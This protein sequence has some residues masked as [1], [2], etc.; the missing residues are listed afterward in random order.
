MHA[1]AQQVVNYGVAGQ[2]DSHY[3]QTMMGS[4]KIVDLQKRIVFNREAGDRMATIMGYLSDVT[5]GGYTVFPTVGAK[6]KPR[7]GSVV[8][9]WN[10][11]KGIVWGNWPSICFAQN[12]F[13]LP[14]NPS[15]FKKPCPVEAHEC[16]LLTV[17]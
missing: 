2:Y 15:F 10:M 3:D 1:I 17:Y 8:V 7:R 6:V 16:R 4:G 11:D 13:I 12:L 5:A 9:W 14:T